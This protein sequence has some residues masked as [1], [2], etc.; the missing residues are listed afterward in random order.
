MPETTLPPVRE[1]LE[2][3]QAAAVADGRIS[4]DAA[5]HGAA[6]LIPAF[7]K[8]TVPLDHN[9]KP[10]IGRG[11][12][13][14]EPGAFAEGEKIPPV[15]EGSV[16]APAALV[17]AASAAP[18]AAAAEA[19]A[20]AGV[21]PAQAAAGAAAA[22]AAA[23][24]IADE[25]EEF[26][27]TDPNWE[28]GEIKIPVRVPKR[29]AES[30]KR[31][32]DK[33]TSYDRKMSYLANA[34]PV[35]RDLILD[36]RINQLLPLIQ[37]AIA[38]EAYGK[39]V[40][41]GFRRAESGQPLIDA[42]VR[43]IQAPAAPVQPQ[44]PQFVDPFVD[45]RIQTLEERLAAN[46]RATNE[47]RQAQETQAQTQRQRQEQIN[48]NNAFMAAGHR[49]LANAYPGVFKPELGERDPAFQSAME[50]A[51]QAGY[52]NSYDLRAALVFGG[53]G[54][55]SLEAERIAATQSPA[56]AALAGA[57][58][59]LLDTATR[60]AA[61]AARTVSGGASAQTTLPTPPPKPTP[62]DAQGNLKDRQQF[63]DE[64]V[65]WETAFGRLK[66][67]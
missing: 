53:Q 52:T 2:Q 51:R 41:E 67:A 22:E 65:A 15:A 66:Q 49:D 23:A 17:P 25:Y 48:R 39:Y 19:S 46:E 27:F 64:V 54:W 58:S 24:T 63:M 8:G 18:A 3:I 56:A 45:P 57:E 11:T 7:S 6:A 14:R 35:L 4:A 62:K 33:R 60:E 59:R 44:E 28:G 38:D 10:I 61:A 26:E 36:G 40:T 13:D 21:A 16:A 47:W 55:R 9:G 43:E 30:A 1:K 12:P 42:A 20:P 50:Y 31:G 37:R 29:Y 34:E 5:D 32:Y